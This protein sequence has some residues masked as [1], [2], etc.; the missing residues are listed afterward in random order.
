MPF[1]KAVAGHKTQIHVYRNCQ[2]EEELAAIWNVL[3][4]TQR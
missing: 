3:F 1:A 2:E 4:V